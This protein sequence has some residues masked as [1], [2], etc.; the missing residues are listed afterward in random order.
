MIDVAL[1]PVGES[2]D[3]ALEGGDL[4]LEHG[5]RTAALVSLFSDGLA[6]ADDELPDGGTD[7]RGWWAAEALETDRGDRWGSRLWL[8]ERAKLLDATLVRAEEHA[9]EA[10]AW[11]LRVG[12]AERVEASAARLDLGTMLVEVRLVRGAATQRADLWAAELAAEV[13]VGP[14]RFRLVAVP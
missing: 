14:T 9:R 10:F 6:E 11:A 8:L 3:L 4:K 1:V 7:R 5:L 13:E 2:L 12:L